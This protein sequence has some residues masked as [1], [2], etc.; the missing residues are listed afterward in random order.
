MHHPS[1][2]SSV[3]ITTAFSSGQSTLSTSSTLQE[4]DLETEG[5]PPNLTTTL[6]GRRP[7]HAQ[8][9]A[10]SLL[11]P[12]TPAQLQ[13]TS[14]PRTLFLPHTYLTLQSLL[15]FLYTSSLP[16]PNSRLCPPQTLCSL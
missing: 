16:P 7:S 6:P 12:P 14:R 2:N 15:Y 10:A 5:L 9:E 13:P 8:K 4:A 11:T 1:R 3:T